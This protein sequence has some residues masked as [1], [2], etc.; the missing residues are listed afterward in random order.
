VTLLGPYAPDGSP[1][2]VYSLIGPAE[3]PGIVH[4]AIPKGAEILEL[5]S[6]VGRVTRALI[7]LGHPVVAVDE[8]PDMLARVAG[9]ETVLSRIEELDLDRRFPVVLLASNLIN[10]EDRRQRAAFL[11][12]CRNHVSPDGVVLIERLEPDLGARIEH[13]SVRERD[14]VQIWSEKV[15]QRGKTLSAEV[16]YRAGDREWIHPFTAELLDDEDIDRVL[17]D[18]GFVLDRWLDEARRWFAA[19][20]A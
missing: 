13:G 14:G 4:S 12:T 17:R 6:G 16:H 2:E 15:A 19:R 5:G 18:S 1:V 10:T 8:S 9:A 20:P 3:E 11:R 7:E